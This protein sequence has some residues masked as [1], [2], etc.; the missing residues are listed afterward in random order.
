MSCFSDTILGSKEPP[1]HVE[2][3]INW[4]NLKKIQIFKLRKTAYDVTENQKLISCQRLICKSFGIF[5]IDVN[6][7]F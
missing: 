1:Y 3:Q 6:N 7:K 2:S 4:A 5:T